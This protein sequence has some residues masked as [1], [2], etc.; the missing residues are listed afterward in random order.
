MIAELVG[1]QI[2]MDIVLFTGLVIQHTLS[3]I[4]ELYCHQ[5]IHT[6]THTHTLTH[7]H[8]KKTKNKKKTHTQNKIHSD[9]VNVF[10][11]KV[12]NKLTNLVISRFN[13]G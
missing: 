8:T 9:A 11:L 1:R 5:H 13:G 12:P 7:T 2:H 6:N 10:I 4:I 3:H